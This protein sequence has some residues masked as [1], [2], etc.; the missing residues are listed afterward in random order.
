MREFYITDKAG[1]FKDDIDEAF[2]Y[3]VEEIKNC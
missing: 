3:S 2:I 1:N